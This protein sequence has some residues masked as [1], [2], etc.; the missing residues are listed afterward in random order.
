[1]GQAVPVYGG[2]YS[3]AVNTFSKRHASVFACLSVLSYVATCVMGARAG[4]EYLFGIFKIDSSLVIDMSTGVVIICVALIV[5]WGLKESTRVAI[6][7]FV[8][9]GIVLT[10]L[11]FW[12]LVWVSMGHDTN[13]D[14]LFDHSL[15]NPW[16]T[17]LLFGFSTGMLGIT[18]YE[19]ACNYIEEQEEGVYV[20]ALRNMWILVT[21][22]NPLVSFFCLAVMDVDYIYHN[23]GDLLDHMGSHSIGKFLDEEFHTK[24]GA[25][26]ARDLVAA[27]A[28]VVLTGS[29]LTAFIGVSGLL[30]RLSS[31]GCLP[32]SLLAVNALSLIHI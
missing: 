2:V 20:K 15:P 13:L 1:M 3:A 27:D 29:V 26:F 5:M 9:H 30:A 4:C 11:L 32:Q 31:D 23:Q 7:I 28:F 16:P 6:G 22:V 12:S 17:S 8:V 14:K 10:M 19:T 18:G 21:L 24:F 25:S